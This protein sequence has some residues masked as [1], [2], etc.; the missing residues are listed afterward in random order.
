MEI[1]KI[2]LLSLVLFS[3]LNISCSRKVHLN[4]SNIKLKKDSTII[5]KTDSISNT[6]SNYNVVTNAEEIEIV[7]VVDSLPIIIDGKTYFNA[8]LRH[9]NTKVVL[10]NTEEKNVAKNTSKIIQVKQQEKN[11]QKQKEIK[12]NSYINY[13]IYILII[14]ILIILYKYL[15]NKLYNYIY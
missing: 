14:I 4:K 11:I 12:N 7:P 10:S 3:V 15:F 5:F 13:Y 8:V 9:K 1:K 6:K 2:L